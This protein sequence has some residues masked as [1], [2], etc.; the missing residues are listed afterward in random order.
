MKKIVKT[1]CSALCMVG[2]SVPMHALAVTNEEVNDLLD[3]KVEQSSDSEL[4][5]NYHL[6]FLTGDFG[7]MSTSGHLTEEPIDSLL[8][9]TSNADGKIVKNAQVV[10][11]IINQTGEQEMSRALPYRG[12]YDIGIDQLSAGRYRLETEVATNGQL[13]TDEF[14]F[15]RA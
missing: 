12:G 10:Y 1:M 6:V 8:L 2:L 9:F 11:T 14:H 7:L 3:D 15:F 5:D 13:L 4:Q